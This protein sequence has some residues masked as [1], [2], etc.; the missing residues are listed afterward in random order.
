VALSEV[1]EIDDDIEATGYIEVSAHLFFKIHL[2][3][4]VVKTDDRRVA[5]ECGINTFPALVYFRRNNPI[6][7]DGDFK[8]SETVL[9]WLRSHDEV[10]TW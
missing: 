4:K 7:Y 1:E 9:R 3:I 10:A 8:D 6:F 5:R 2:K